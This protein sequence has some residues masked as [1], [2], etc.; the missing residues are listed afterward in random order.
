[1]TLPDP[2]DLLR[3]A[4]AAYRQGS[5]ATAE[6]LCLALLRADPGNVGGLFLLAVLHLAAGRDDAAAGLFQ[7]VLT[8]DPAIADAHGNLAMIRQ[9]QG[10]LGEAA[11][12]FDRAARLAPDKAGWR[13]G[14]ALL[15]LDQPLAAAR[16]LRHVLAL[17][18]AS[19]PAWRGLGLARRAAGDPAGAARAL[20]RAFHIDPA[21]DLADSEAFA[22]RLQAADWRDYAARRQRIV[23]RIDQGGTVLPLLT[24]WIGIDPARQRR[25]AEAIFGTRIVS[26]PSSPLHRR[27]IGD[28]PLTVAY[29]SADFHDHATAH[30]ITGLFECH[31]R[32]HFRILAGCYGRDDDSAARRRIRQAVD[33]FHRLDSLTAADAATWAAAQGIDILVDLKGYTAG[34]RLD[35]LSRRLAP[36]QVSYL[37]YP[38][39]LGGPALDYLIGDPVVTPA[40]DQP[41]YTEQLVLLPDCYQV[42]DRQRPLPTAPDPAA[43]PAAGFVFGALHAP[44]KLTPD[45]FACWLRLLHA[46]P[47]ACLHL[48]DPHGAASPTLRAA[49]QA[50][51]IDPARLII[52]GQAPLAAHLARYRA[53]DLC[54][55]SFPYTGHTTSSDALWMGVPVITCQGEGFAAR[56]TASLLHAVGLPDLITHD[57]AG[58]EALALSLAQAPDRLARLKAHL[59]RVRSTTPLFDTARFTR[60]LETAYR[61][62]GDR[63]RAGLPPAGFSVPPHA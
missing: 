31:D 62:M 2:T 48:H 52:S 15:R 63:Y 57:R 7:A 39:T 4:M 37:G 49:A 46:V 16:D 47:G 36:V 17:D 56:V 12:L 3:A 41:F 61:I 30:L 50:A 32:R 18:P 24:Q 27:A 11:A 40:T 29:L 26:L 53:I 13:V 25:A 51:G 55:D 35:L 5:M 14:R 20:D 59:E 42:N 10:R 45:L 8:L 9:R 6:G 34:A 1:M 43:G 58:Y 54:L 60:H 19:A 33:G 28:G 23:D 44:H 21:L 38:G 22:C